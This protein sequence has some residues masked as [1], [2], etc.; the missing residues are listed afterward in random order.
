MKSKTVQS[1]DM[2]N[3]VHIRRATEEDTHLLFEIC[4]LSYCALTGREDI[5]FLLEY[6]TETYGS[7]S[8]AFC[9]EAALEQWFKNGGDREGCMWIANVNDVPTG[10]VYVELEK[11]VGYLSE[12]HILPGWQQM[13]IGNKLI[14]TCEEWVFTRGLP[15][16]LEAHERV[17]QYFLNKGY[18][19]SCKKEPYIIMLIKIPSIFWKS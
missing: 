7:D 15:V 9:S 18:T 17:I 13:G 10:F 1:S 16:L 8:Y 6:D 5:N 14:S 12:V 2:D 3:T 11:N 19:H 4:R